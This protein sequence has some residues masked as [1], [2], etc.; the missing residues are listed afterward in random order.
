MAFFTNPFFLKFQTL[1]KNNKVLSLW[2]TL[3]V[4]ID[5][6]L[7]F[8]TR[9]KE[10]T[11]TGAVLNLFKKKNLANN[12]YIDQNVLLKAD[13][14]EEAFLNRTKIKNNIKKFNI[15]NYIIII[16][17]NNDLKSSSLKSQ[18]IH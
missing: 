15:I 4:V 1:V 12:N 17:Y 8:Y 6:S 18:S 10:F 9:D 13:G 3:S 7:L 2:I 11:I 16:L 14:K 5:S